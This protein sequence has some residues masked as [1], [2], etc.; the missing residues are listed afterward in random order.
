[1]IDRA[2]ILW[3]ETWKFLVTCDGVLDLKAA[4]V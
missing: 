4:L 1:M 3:E 2:D